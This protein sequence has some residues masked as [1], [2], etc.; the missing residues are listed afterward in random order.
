MKAVL[1]RDPAHPSVKALLGLA[2][3]SPAT[4]AL[5]RGLLRALGQR[6]LAEITHHFG[7]THTS[8]YW[9]LTEEL[10]SYRRRFAA[11][12]EAAD[13]GPIDLIL[14]PAC[15]LPAFP[16]GATKDLGV[17]GANTGLFNVLGYPAGVVPVTRVRA[18]EE[19]GRRKSMDVVLKAARACDIGSCG[20]PVGVQIAAR[21]WRE[22]E[23][24]AAMRA[25]ERTARLSDGYPQLPPLLRRPAGNRKAALI[26]LLAGAARAAPRGAAWAQGPLE[27]LGLVVGQEHL[28]AAARRQLEP[29]ALG[30]AGAAGIGGYV[31]FDH[32]HVCGR[33]PDQTG[34]PQERGRQGGAPAVQQGLMHVRPP[35]TS[36]PPRPS[37]ACCSGRR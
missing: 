28:D 21:P 37:R 17:A 12:M 30:Q 31:G 1:G 34:K 15:A 27:H 11:A 24:L 13:G 6:S 26:P 23:A 5:L 33:R 3:R 18:D 35:V 20:L 19:G 7:H 29:R 32:L 25:I 2:G 9:R 8:A 4:L 14:G 36:A 10:M 16:H 22:H